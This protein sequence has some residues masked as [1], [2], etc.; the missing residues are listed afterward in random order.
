VLATINTYRA[1]AGLRPV[2]LDD[3]LSVG[4]HAHAEYM[5]TNRGAPQVFA[6]HAHD[7][8]PSLPGA[9]P[10]GAA[11][12]KAANL[13]PEAPDPERAVH[14]WMGSLYHRRAI[15][16]PEVERIG[17]GLAEIGPGA[18][19][20]VV[21]FAYGQTVEAAVLYPANGAS[22]VPLDFQSEVPNPLPPP[23][24]H[25]G[26]PITLQVPWIDTVTNAVGTLDD[27]ARHVPVFF[28]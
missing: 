7:E 2:A 17:V 3:T 8:D 6:L 5:K 13:H 4:C 23:A 20:V 16:T 19:V 11:C 27:G 12:A 24:V 15:L 21:Q 1:A 14:A 22:N 25:A 28:S 9:T 18:V 26:Y 10:A